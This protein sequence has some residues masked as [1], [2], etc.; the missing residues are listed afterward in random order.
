MIW[1]GRNGAKEGKTAITGGL[2]G[3]HGGEEKQA[4]IAG[5]VISFNYLL[6]REEKRSRAGS[7]QPDSIWSAAGAAALRLDCDQLVLPSP[8]GALAA[9]RCILWRRRDRQ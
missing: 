9:G 7:I 1:C 2:S 6:E 5:S 8:W 3:I 4:G